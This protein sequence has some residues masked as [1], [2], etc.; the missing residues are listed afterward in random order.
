M[1]IEAD[2]LTGTTDF[3]DGNCNI[4]VRTPGGAIVNGPVGPTVT[5]PGMAIGNAEQCQ[6]WIALPTTMPDGMYFLSVSVTDN[7][8]DSVE[9]E[10]HVI[11]MCNDVPGPGDSDPGNGCIWADFDRDGA[12]EGLF[13]DLFTLDNKSCDNCVGLPNPSQTD[14]NA[15][16]VG[17]DCEPSRTYGRCEVDRD[18]VCD[19]GSDEVCV[20]Q[21][22]GESIKEHPITGLH[23][24]PQ[25]CHRPWGLCTYGGEVCFDDS[26]C[27]GG[28]APGGAGW[29]ADGITACR[30]EQDCIDAGIGPSAYPSS[31]C[32]GADICDNLIYPWLQTV[33]GNMFSR[34]KVLAPEGPP[35]SKFNA[36]FCITARDT[37][38]N[39][40][41][42]NNC[43]EVDIAA[44]YTFPKPEND[45]TTVLGQIDVEGLRAGKYGDVIDVPAGNLDTT[46]MSF[47]GRLGGRV[48][49]V[50]GDVTVSGNIIRNEAA[51]E[52][53]SGTIF[54][55]GGNLTITGNILYEAA[56]AETTRSLASLGWIVLDDGTDTRGNLYI[57]RA[58]TSL[59]G[60]FYVGGKDGIWSVAAPDTEG[61][62]QLRV[63][64][65]MIAR[66]FHF[67]RSHK[68]LTEG[69]EQVIF[70]GRAVANPPPG[71]EDLGKY[72]PRFTDSAP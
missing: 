71:F 28:P 42:E 50:T 63:Y 25:P 68:S 6:G 11:Y 45:Y 20:Y 3:F 19:C 72:L 61:E 54:V 1:F 53:G 65:L 56:A 8:G 13:T 9:T 43:V 4:Y 62:N 34:K 41:S 5:M 26:E 66:Q 70:D 7:D 51:G 21:C 46:I 55:D 39:F 32:E 16:G 10:R 64:G 22:P 48:L 23:L 35:D 15:N 14:V 18:I 44:R 57:N 29:C 52:D 12:G 33:Y 24:N 36:T 69:S 37:I 67:S 59:A 17:D 30:K 49:R 31:A 58:V 38:L 47:G 40:T 60:A 2:F 27:L